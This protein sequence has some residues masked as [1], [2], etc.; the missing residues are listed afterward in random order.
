MKQKLILTFIL[1]FNCSHKELLSFSSTNLE[2]YL[3]KISFPK[4]TKEKS[5]TVDGGI[6]EKE[7]LITL[8]LCKILSYQEMMD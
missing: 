7:L 5:K 1:F 3:N 8:Q 6:T 4:Y 2:T